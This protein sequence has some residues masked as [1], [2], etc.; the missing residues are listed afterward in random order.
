MASTAK[1][2]VVPGAGWNPEF[3]E[4]FPGYSRYIL[5]D[6][7]PEHPHYEPHHPGW[8]RCSTR[9]VFFETLKTEFGAFDRIDEDS[10]VIY[11]A[12]GVMEYWFST[13][14]ELSKER[15]ETDVDAMG[16]DVF[17]DAYVP[18]DWHDLFASDCLKRVFMSCTTIAAPDSV[19]PRRCCLGIPLKKFMTVHIGCDGEPCDCEYR[20]RRYKYNKDS[21]SEYESDSGSSDGCISCDEDKMACDETDCNKD[22]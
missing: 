7:M 8:V 12:N 3:L 1:T 20:M 19:W 21:D 16:F 18:Y 6:T 15:L 17:F 14:A 11:F 9:E 5:I 4:L 2:L 10:K 13:N 22:S